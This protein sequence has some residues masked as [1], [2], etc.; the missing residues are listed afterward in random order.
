[1]EIHALIDPDSTDSY[2]YT[3]QLFDKRPSI[4]QLEYDTHVTSPLGHSVNVNRVYKNFPIMIHDRK[5]SM[6]PIALPFCEYDLILRMDCLSKHQVIIDC[7]KK[8]VILKCPDQSTVKVQG[9]IFD[10][11]SNVIST[12]QAHR[13]LRKGC[14]AFLALVP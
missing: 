14:E 9:I 13:F 2:V 8:S 4:E 5:F 11:L 10:P 12:M 7:D 1:M 3:E 6:D